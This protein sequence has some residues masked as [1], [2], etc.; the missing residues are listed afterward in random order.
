MNTG[1]ISGLITW[2]EPND[3]ATVTMYAVFLAEDPLGTQQLQVGSGNVSFGTNQLVLGTIDRGSRDWLLVYTVNDRGLA[4]NAS[5]FH[6]FDQ[7]GYGPRVSISSL[8]FDDTNNTFGFISGMVTWREPDDSATVQQYVVH[9]VDTATDFR[10][11]L[12]LVMFGTN[13]LDIPY[14]LMRNGSTIIA[15]YTRNVNGLQ[16]VR[17]GSQTVIW[18]YDHADVPPLVSVS[19]AEFVDVDPVEGK[20]GGTVTWVPPTNIVSVNHYVVALTE[21]VAGALNTTWNVP[22]GTNELVIV[23]GTDRFASDLSS[24]I[25]A[26]VQRCRKHLLVYHSTTPQQ[27]V[28]E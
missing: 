20:I 23:N 17:E 24:C 15:V 9:L 22:R 10:Y 4:S 5:A 12:D 7:D 8:H 3:S 21:D 6:I 25:Q 19:N 18:I 28:H 1:N 27:T 14:P 16:S 13:Q 26:V 11:Q 2:H